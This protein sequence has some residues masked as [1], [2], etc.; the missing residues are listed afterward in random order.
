MKEFNNE[1]LLI[2]NF[3]HLKIIALPLEIPAALKYTKRQ[4]QVLPWVNDGKPL[5]DVSVLL[6]I[7]GHRQKT[8]SARPPRFGR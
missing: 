1:I 3:V 8:Y 2:N 6:N 5:Y 7:T 4:I